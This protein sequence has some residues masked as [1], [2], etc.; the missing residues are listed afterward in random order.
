LSAVL[1]ECSIEV[2]KIATPATE[3]PAE[4]KVEVMPLEKTGS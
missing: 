4:P 1:A 3:P 2:E